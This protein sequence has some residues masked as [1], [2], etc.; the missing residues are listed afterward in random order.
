MRRMDRHGEMSRGCLTFE[1][2]GLVC[3]AAWVL[4]L[5]VGCA[6]PDRLTFDNYSSVNNKM[7][8]QADVRAALGEP[9]NILGNKWLYERPDKHLTVMIDFDKDGKIERKQW[10][11]A[12]GVQWHDTDDAKRPTPPK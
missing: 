10:V 11:D 6:A 8:T 9:D 5:L 7:S 1:R 3:F 4:V 2:S 12:S